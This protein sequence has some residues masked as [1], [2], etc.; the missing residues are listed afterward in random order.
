MINFQTNLLIHIRGI[1]KRVYR[2][3]RGSLM[4]VNF[5]QFVYLWNSNCEANRITSYLINYAFFFP[6]IIVMLLYSILE[7]LVS[8][9]IALR[10]NKV[11]Q[12]IYFISS[13]SEQSTLSIYK[14]PFCKKDSESNLV[15]ISIEEFRE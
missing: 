11:K 13:Y 10:F 14:K 5:Q 6:V 12:G 15:K 7:I 1:K 8:N 9:L 3:F 2:P 4:P